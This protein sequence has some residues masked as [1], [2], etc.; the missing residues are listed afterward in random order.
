VIDHGG[1]EEGEGRREE[2]GGRREEGGSI[3]REMMY[4]WRH[5]LA[6]GI[7]GVSKGKASGSKARKVLWALGGLGARR[8]GRI[9]STGTVL[10]S[11]DQNTRGRGHS[12]G[13]TYGS[14][15]VVQYT[16]HTIQVAEGGALH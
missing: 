15:T 5:L 14:S 10:Y 12:T 16:Q 7:F 11:F 2:G 1:I 9:R 6:L 4:R 8:G 3:G 13:S